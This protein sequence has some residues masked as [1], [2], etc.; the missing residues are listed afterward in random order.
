MRKVIALALLLGLLNVGA[1]LTPARA[2]QSAMDLIQQTSDQ[3]LAALR[4]N[5]AALEQDANKIYPL[6]NDILLPHFDAATMARWVLGKYWR[7]AS[8]QQRNQFV[9]LF[10]AFLVRTYGKALLAYSDEKIVYKSV[11]PRKN[12]RVVVQA[13]VQAGGAPPVPV[14]YSLRRNKAGAWK[15]YDVKVDGISLVTNYRNSFAAQIRRNGMDALINTLSQR[16]REMG[17]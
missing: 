12:N 11:L 6:I 17:S 7:E 8:K 15:V 10:S 13:E 2:D 14:H 3:M 16:N 5:R 4:D 9:D 1:L